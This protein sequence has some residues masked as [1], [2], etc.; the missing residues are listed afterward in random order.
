MFWLQFVS[1]FIKILREGQTPAQI[2][3]GLALGFMAGLS[4]HLTL[5][6]LIVWAIILIL[7]VNLSA[8]MLGFTVGALLAFLFD[9]IFHAVGYFALVDVDPL[10]G[11]WTALYNAPLAP[12]T[13]FNN[14]VIM[15]SFIGGIVLLPVLFFGMRWFVVE[16]RSTLAKR[17]ERWKVYQVLRQNVL[18]RWY[19][20]L[21]DIGG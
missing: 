7:D 9:P 17:F 18:V 2:A 3:G 10:Q 1:K 5:Q 13:R 8:A 4:P 12:L 14:T 11:L 19:I 20:K 16:Y 6:I 21:R 15:G